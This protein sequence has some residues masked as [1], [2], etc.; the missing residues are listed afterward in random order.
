MT[1]DR[2]D[3]I[4]SEVPRVT[5]RHAL[6]AAD[7]APALPPAGGADKTYRRDGKRFV[8]IAAGTDA[9]ASRNGS[10]AGGTG[11]GNE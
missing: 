11:I 10:A 7:A 2:K 5:A 9:D 3:A 6:A 8:Q 4:M 1:T